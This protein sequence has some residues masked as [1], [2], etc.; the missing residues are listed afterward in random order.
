MTKKNILTAAVS[1]ALVAVLAVGSTLAYLTDETA[2]V[3]NKF[4][5]DGLTITLKENASVPADQ[6]YKIQENSL[7]A[8]RPNTNPIN[9]TDK[10]VIYTDILPGAT[11][12]KNP[13]IT[14]SD[15][16]AHAYVY[17]YV[18]GVTTDTEADIYTTWAK[19]W[20]PVVTDELKGTLLRRDVAKDAAGTYN[21]FTQVHVS[22][23]TDGSEALNDIT[24]EAF[25][26]QADNVDENVADTAAIAHFKG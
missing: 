19:G 13:Y 2:K 1:T 12:E 20:T 5:M 26:H 4:Q 21:I 22:I 3:D 6:F 25:A 24:I 9:G 17:A 11:V 10:G 16:N 14:V 7:T 18:E 15:S 8:A 23:D